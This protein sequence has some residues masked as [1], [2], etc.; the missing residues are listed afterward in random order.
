MNIFH[1]CNAYKLFTFSIYYYISNIQTSYFFLVE[2]KLNWIVQYFMNGAQI[3]AIWG[4]A[5]PNKSIPRLYLSP[6]FSFLASS[7]KKRISCEGDACFIEG[8]WNLMMRY[9]YLRAV[10]EAM[11]K[12]NESKW[13]E[14]QTTSS[15]FIG[16]LGFAKHAIIAASIT[17]SL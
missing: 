13:R 5:Q 9:I 10:K 14:K 12:K 4:W 8:G 16:C 1:L 7:R 17:F 2:N 6:P 15:R 11:Q 3:D